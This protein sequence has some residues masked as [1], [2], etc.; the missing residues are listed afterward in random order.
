MLNVVL[1][2]AGAMLAGANFID[3]YNLQSM[4]AQ[5]PELGLLAFA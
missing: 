2:T 3:S 5:V 1:L 4:A